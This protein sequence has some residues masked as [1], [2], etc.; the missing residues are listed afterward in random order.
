MDKTMDSIIVIGGGHVGLTLAVDL[1]LR[2]EE[3]KLSPHV[4][5][6][7][8]DH[9]FL[10][11]SEE[12][13]IEVEDILTGKV[14]YCDFP[15]NKIHTFDANIKQLNDIKVVAVVVTVP[16]IPKLRLQVLNW[17]MTN[18][19]HEKVSII[20]VRGGQGGQI[21]IIDTW[22]N[23]LLL[24]KFNIILIEDSFY[25]TRYLNHKIVFKRKMTTNVSIFGPSPD[26]ASKLLSR[27]FTSDSINPSFHAFIKV[28]PLDLQFDPLGYIIHLGVSLDKRNLQL[29]YKGV[30]YL[31]YSDGV[32]EENADLIEKLDKE[33]VRLAE[34]YSAKTKSFADILKCQYGIS[35]QSSFLNMM[36]STKSIYRSLSPVSI[37]SLINGRIIQEDVP[38]LF[39]M[40]LLAKKAEK[41]LPYTYRHVEN[42]LTTLKQLNIDISPLK[43]YATEIENLGLS[44]NN[45]IN[46]LTNPM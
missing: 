13:N 37:N 44:K 29:T 46:L 3:T 21:K 10:N 38:A 26:S 16:D 30:Q 40:E 1:E 31:H 41:K 25:G 24:R 33:R 35:Y 23:N 8:E 32:H 7:S 42:I 4:L 17:I 2:K 15:K 45:I 14:L 22:Q 12:Q 43:L 20:F 27:M 28:S 18:I 36:K 34:S 39:T 11:R 19:T 6:M 9:G 5:V